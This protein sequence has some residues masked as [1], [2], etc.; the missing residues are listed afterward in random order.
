MGI[1]HGQTHIQNQKNFKDMINFFFSQSI[2]EKFPILK[3]FI[4]IVNSSTI[5]NKI[6]GG[7]SGC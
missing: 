7:D 2:K 1:S 5:E 6:L 4:R 3:Y